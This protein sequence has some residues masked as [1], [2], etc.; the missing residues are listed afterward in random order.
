MENEKLYQEVAEMINRDD[1]HFVGVSITPA[2][3][4]LLSLQMTPDEARLA[5]EVG[6]QG[7]TLYE[8]AAKTGKDK[9]ALKKILNTMADKG[10]MWIDPGKEYPKYR[11]LG[12]CAPGFTE[13]GLM[14]NIRFPYDLELAKYLHQTLYEWIRDKMCK[15]GFPFAPVW[16]HPWVLPEDAKPEENLVE[17]LKS[18][19]FFCLSTCP[20][21]LSHWISEPDNHCEHMLQTCLHSGDTG[22]WC[23]DHGMGREITLDEAIDLLRKTNAEGLVHTINIEGFICNCCT[24]CCPL[25]IG[26]HKL[27]TQTMIPSPFIPVIDEGECTACGACIDMCPVNALKLEDAA[28]LDI[29]KCI[30]CGVCVTHCDMNAIKLIRRA[31]QIDLPDEVKGHVDKL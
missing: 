16:A 5:L 30:G 13:T 20:C 18:Q 23:V 11:I 19:N 2:F 4:K 27:N 1:P 17:F 14:G 12:S 10:T 25:F 21:R 7:M 3:L 24:D 8:I 26:L 31:Q 28:E 29:D 9:A 22:R 6:L 15:L